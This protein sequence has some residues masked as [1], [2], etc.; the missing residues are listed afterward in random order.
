M[1]YVPRLTG[2]YQPPPEYR[3]PANATEN[4]LATISAM[5]DPSGTLERLQ[6]EKVA[7]SMADVKLDGIDNLYRNHAMGAIND[8]QQFS[9]NQY[10]QN[11]GLNR[12]NL[13]GQQTIEQDRKYKELITGINALKD[14]SA[15]YKAT[16][17]QAGRDIGDK[18]TPEDYKAF[19]DELTAKMNSAK[20]IGDLPMAHAVYNNFLAKMPYDWEKMNKD[21]AAGIGTPKV[22]KN[23]D[24]E[25][26]ERYDT[27]KFD[28]TPIAINLYQNNNR[29]R[30][31]WRD[32]AGGDDVLGMKLNIDNAVDKYGIKNRKWGGTIKTGGNTYVNA[33]GVKPKYNPRVIKKDGY[34][35][36]NFSAKPVPD[37]YGDVEG[38]YSDV[39]VAPD[40][41]AEVFMKQIVNAEGKQVEINTDADVMSLF[42]D[43]KAK[44]D[45]NK[46]GGVWL[47]YNDQVEWALQVNEYNTDDI[48]AR[49]GE[50]TEPG[51]KVGG[52]PAKVKW[53]KFKRKDGTWQNVT[54]SALQDAGIDVKSA[55]AAG[56]I[57]E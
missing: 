48:K 1:P 53:Y 2:L 50:Y 28:P 40:G 15:D 19:E 22:V 37:S 42:P 9:T 13:T 45:P 35:Y 21:L 57:K 4:N 18:I 10:K 36:Y 26:N 56:D 54:M 43:G 34:T 16:L 49:K 7:R 30:K 24:K 20:S 32:Q 12:L 23:V 29:Y 5:A 33:A 51:E 14:M 17:T 46:S 11:K 41:T 8:Y 31:F 3:E 39:R 47:P 6:A 55:I 38:K 27:E 25:G 44:R 52:E